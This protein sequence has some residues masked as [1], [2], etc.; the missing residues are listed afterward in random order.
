MKRGIRTQPGILRRQIEM[1]SDHE[2]FE[3]RSEYAH[4]GGCYYASRMA[5]NELLT[6]ERKT[7]GA[8]IFREAHPGYVM[9]VGVWNVRERVRESL[10]TKPFSFDTLEGALRHIDNVMDIPRKVWLH[11]SEI[12]K[13]FM[14]QRRIDDYVDA[15]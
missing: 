12:L 3:G 13:D 8:V 9:P 2:F 5:I 15:E 14:I 10:T 11:H 4:I 1:I 6:K 7:A